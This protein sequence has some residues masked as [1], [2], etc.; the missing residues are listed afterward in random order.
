MLNIS[1]R[2]GFHSLTIERTARHGTKS[3]RQYL[4]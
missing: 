4:P 1:T 3:S 2:L